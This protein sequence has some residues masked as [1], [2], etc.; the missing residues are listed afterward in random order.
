MR[1][2]R[3]SFQETSLKIYVNTSLKKC[4]FRCKKQEFIE[5]KTSN[6]WWCLLKYVLWMYK[7]VSHQIQHTIR[8]I[9]DSFRLWCSLTTLLVAAM[10]VYSVVSYKVTQNITM[11]TVIAINVSLIHDIGLLTMYIIQLL[12]LL[13]L[14]FGMR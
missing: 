1:G 9:V 4:M 6:I 11:L 10:C 3:H 13:F 14:L 8:C 12:P 2:N 7:T 5:K